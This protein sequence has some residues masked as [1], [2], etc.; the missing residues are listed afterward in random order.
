LDTLKHLRRLADRRRIGIAHRG[1]SCC[2]PDVERE[3][4]A[5]DNQRRDP[6]GPDGGFG[7][8]APGASS[9]AQPGAD[10]LAIHRSGRRWGQPDATIGQT[11][12]L[13]YGQA[14]GANRDEQSQRFNSD[15]GI[16][17][18]SNFN[19][20]ASPLFGQTLPDVAAGANANTAALPD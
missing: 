2:C 3:A 15:G 20:D 14:G 10:G 16:D 9:F 12:R 17:A 6:A 5:A 18:N 7:S 13:A 11:N 8:A 4:S 1:V 19:R